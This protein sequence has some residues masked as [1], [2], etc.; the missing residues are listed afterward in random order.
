VLDAVDADQVK[1]LITF[2]ASSARA[3]LRGEAH[4]STANDWMSELTVKF[5]EEHPQARC[6]RWSGRC[7]RAQAWASGWV[8][9]RR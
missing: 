2:A 6:W 8:S 7:G 5:G 1:L 3:G 9:S 4:Y